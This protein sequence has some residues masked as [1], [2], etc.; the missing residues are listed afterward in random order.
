MAAGIRVLQVFLFPNVLLI[1]VWAT[2]E[3]LSI[4]IK[5]GILDLG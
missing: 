5:K 3:E 1:A 2:K 4:V